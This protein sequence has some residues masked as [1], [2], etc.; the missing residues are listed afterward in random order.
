MKSAV[1][2]MPFG[3]NVLHVGGLTCTTIM[4]RFFYTS[5]GVVFFVEDEFFLCTFMVRYC[6][7]NLLRIL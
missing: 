1:G 2:A 4:V 5:V 6:P 3:W 7:S